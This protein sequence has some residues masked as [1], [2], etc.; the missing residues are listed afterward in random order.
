[1][2]DNVTII[3]KN[4]LPIEK[5]KKIVS[6]VG[7]SYIDASPYPHIVIDQLFDHDILTNIFAEFPK[8]ADIEWTN[9]KNARE[10]KLASNKD[11]HFGPYTKTMLYHLNSAPFLNFLTEITGINNLIADSYLDGGGMHQIQ[12]GGKLAVHADFNRHSGTKLDRRLNALLYL[13]PEWK[14]EYGGELELWDRDMARCQKKIEPL[15]NRLVVFSTTDF[16][17]HGHPE[18]LNCPSDMTRK[19]LALYYFTNGRPSDEISEAHSTLFRARPGENIN[20]TNEKI[21]NLVKDVLPPFVTRL[22][23]KYT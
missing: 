7:T 18:P 5:M 15:F 1:M 22:I 2:L 8:P 21:K 14:S 3:G 19:S 17:Y 12:R 20:P 16:T 4:F 10:V 6:T 9:Y 11:E 13:N 23:G